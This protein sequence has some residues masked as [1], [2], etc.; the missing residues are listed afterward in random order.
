M[1]TID[2]LPL[3]VALNPWHAN[4]IWLCVQLQL[5]LTTTFH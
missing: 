5:F 4:L 1:E 3:F 2:G